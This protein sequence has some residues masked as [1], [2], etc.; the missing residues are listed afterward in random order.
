MSTLSGEVGKQ[1]SFI[2]RLRQEKNNL[3]IYRSKILRA[4][5]KELNK[6][7]NIFTYR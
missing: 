4:D 6:E 1:Y 3:S 7:L 2:C 5:E